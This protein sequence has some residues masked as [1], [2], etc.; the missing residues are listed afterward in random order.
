MNIKD[1]TFITPTKN[2]ELTT[3]QV[4]QVSDSWV[5][6][7]FPKRSVWALVALAYPQVTR[8]K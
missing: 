3:A 8:K 7:S 1:D 5:Q 4:L 6:L 2:A